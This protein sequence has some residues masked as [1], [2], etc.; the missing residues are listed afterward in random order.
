MKTI[1]GYTLSLVDDID[2]GSL[3]FMRENGL[4]KKDGT[5]YKSVTK[6]ITNYTF[7]GSSYQHRAITVSIDKKTEKVMFISKR[8]S[9]TYY[10]TGDIDKLLGIF[11][12]ADID[13]DGVKLG[14]GYRVDNECL[15]AS[16]GER[17]LINESD[18]SQ[19][20][21][22]KAFISWLNRDNGNM[23]RPLTEKFLVACR[24]IRTDTNRLTGY[25]NV[26]RYL[27]MIRKPSTFRLSSSDSPIIKTDRNI[28]IVADIVNDK[29]ICTTSGLHV[30]HGN[31]DAEPYVLFTTKPV[32][33][34]SGNLPFVIVRSNGFSIFIS[35]FIAN[36]GIN[37]K[38]MKGGF[39]L[40]R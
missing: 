40:L 8:V 36:P 12:D 26:E 25:A 2:S 14:S 6:T 4:L 23:L 10:N 15:H 37:L 18:D 38:A 19:D 39:D 21:F 35:P 1:N 3:E 24:L 9:I 17:Y 7:P 27:R 32:N 11:G 31:S 13:M 34:G 33:F 22:V 5:P 20:G 29:M 30:V 16:N 28:T